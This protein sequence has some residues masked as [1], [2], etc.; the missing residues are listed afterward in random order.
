MRL[1]T[2]DGEEVW[3]R[4]HENEP[5]DEVEVITWTRDGRYVLS[6]GE[7]YHVR[8]WRAEDGAPVRTLALQG[9]I[10]GM[11]MSHSGNRLATG[12][13]TGRI[14][15]WDT[16]APDPNDW[17]D[18]PL[19]VAMQGEDATTGDEAGALQA[20]V[21]SVDWTEDDRFVVSAGR[22]AVVK[23]WEVDAMGDPDEGLRQTYSGF[24]S[25]IKSVR[26]SPDGAFV[27]AGGQKS[28]DALVLVWDYETGEIVKRIAYDNFPK[29][30]AVE[31]SPDGRFLLTGGIEGVEFDQNPEGMADVADRYPTNKGIGHIRVYDREN[32]FALVHEEEVYRQEY[33]HF[34]AD[35]SLLA[36]G[37]ED[38]T[39]R[40]W[41]VAGF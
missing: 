19:Y 32:D 29:I 40:L 3:Q 4:F 5:N 21:N 36:S 8:V 37:H 31:W 10:D 14:S 41:K 30:E 26:L 28:P 13:E 9:S 18:Q 25:S 16:S 7:D 33:L 20:D 27:A 6:A 11:R 35:G 17:P 15:I 39:V 24:E 2:V 34:N 38:G 23:R 22:N 12:D 1:Y